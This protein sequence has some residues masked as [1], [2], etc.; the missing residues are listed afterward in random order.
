M[1]EL[2]KLIGKLLGEDRIKV[3]TIL[4]AT[5]A[6]SGLVSMTAYFSETSR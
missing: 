3:G 4:I 1:N 2:I 6:V 5:A